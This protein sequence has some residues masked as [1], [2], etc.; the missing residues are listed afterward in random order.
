MSPQLASPSAARSFEDLS[1]SSWAPARTWMR[2]KGPPWRCFTGSGLSSMNSTSRSEL[3]AAWQRLGSR[4][5][6]RTKKA[7]GCSTRWSL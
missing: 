6:S 2:S 5:G 3:C 1:Q 7:A 4:V